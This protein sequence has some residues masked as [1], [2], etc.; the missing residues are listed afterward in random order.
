MIRIHEPFRGT[1]LNHRHGRKVKGEL[2]IP[3]GREARTR[4]CRSLTMRSNVCLA[5]V[6]MERCF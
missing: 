6:A 2:E 4:R 3:S 1:V 5:L